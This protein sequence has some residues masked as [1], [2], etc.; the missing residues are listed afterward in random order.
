[1]GPTLPDFRSRLGATTDQI[2]LA[3]GCRDAGGIVGCII[4]GM[5]ADR[6][7]NHVDLEV[8]MALFVS[9]LFCALKPW[10]PGVP[11]LACMGLLEGFGYGTSDASEYTYSRCHIYDTTS[12]NN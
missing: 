11:G 4:G 6:F 12:T 10:M 8:A 2:S 9:G 3:A 7:R 5:L 1:M